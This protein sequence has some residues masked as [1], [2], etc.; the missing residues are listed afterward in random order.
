MTPNEPV[1]ELMCQERHSH[2]EGLI[3]DLRKDVVIMGHIMHGNGKLGMAGKVET[4]WTRHELM[5][6]TTMGWV[7]WLFR[8]VVGA[9][10]S[11]IAVKVGL[12]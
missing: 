9:L 5:Q 3:S 2:T 1:T 12:R 10:L 4:L 7:D 11:Y 6:R 8:F